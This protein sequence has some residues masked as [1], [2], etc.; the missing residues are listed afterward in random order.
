MTKTLKYLKPYG[1]TVF[2]GLVLKLIG[3]VAELFLPMLLEYIIDDVVPRRDMNMILILGG[4]MLIC[5]LVALLSNVYA[6]RLTVRS[7]GN[8]THDLRLELFRRT[9]YLKCGQVDKFGLSSLISRLTS[10]TYYVNQMVARTLRL[11]VRAPILILGGVIIAFTRDVMLACV[12]LACVPFVGLT[13]YFI[14]KRSIPVYFSV[15]RKQDDMVRVTQENVSGVRVVKALS[16]S[17]YECGRFGDITKELA[18]REFK[19]NKIMSLSNPLATL[20]LNIGLIAVIVVGAFRGNSMGTVLAFLSYFVIILNAMIGLSKIF[21]VMSRGAASA[22]RIESVLDEDVT[23]EI[24]QYPAG[25]PQYKLEF[26]SVSFSYNGV[27][28][29]VKNINFAIKKGA[30]LGILGATGSGK[31]TLVNLMLRFYDAREGEIFVDGENVRS[32]PSDVLRKKFGVAFQ[33]DFL[34]AA[35]VRENIDYGRGLA[36]EDIVKAVKAAQADDFVSAVGLDYDL[37]QK[38]SNLSGGQKQRLAV[39]RALA[40]NPEILVLDDSSSALDYATDAALRKSLAAEYAGATKVIVAQRVS[41]VRHAD[42]ILVMDDGEVIGSGTHESL[43]RSCGEYKNIFS[44]QMGGE[45]A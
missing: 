45:Y 34:M 40:G 33:S 6:N 27:R 14:T 3:A 2:W 28:D 22:A 9:S 36:D 4:V 16:K 5:S 43:L 26:R 19:A 13:I 41:S 11:G 21:V 30:T 17:E 23:E 31:S 8:M 24:G 20:I 39:A 44:A 42:L 15:Q 35:S 38:A 12:L 25:D 32:I 37:S 29:N 7:S 10:D 1:V 18:S